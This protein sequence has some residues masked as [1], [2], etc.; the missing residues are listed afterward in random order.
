M[1]ERP[2][3]IGKVNGNIYTTATNRTSTGVGF[4]AAY[5]T[6]AHLWVYDWSC[7]AESPCPGAKT[8]PAYVKSSELANLTC[9]LENDSLDGAG[10]KVFGFH[11]DTVSLGGRSYAN[12]AWIYNSCAAKWDLYY[13][14]RYAAD[15]ADCREAA[16]NCAWWGPIL[17]PYVSASAPAIS[18]VGFRN[19]RLL[20]GGAAVS[21]GPTNTAF[22][23]PKSPWSLLEHSSTSLFAVSSSFDESASHLL[24]ALRGL[25]VVVPSDLTLRISLGAYQCMTC[26]LASTERNAVGPGCAIDPH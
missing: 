11:N 13:Q 3:G 22:S 6:G 16:L 24:R 1:I 7:S 15:L 21:L 5:D 26:P 10:T 20:V 23:S 4:L 18:A 12:R 8:A 25:V 19:V 14:R 17:E 9:Y 2:G